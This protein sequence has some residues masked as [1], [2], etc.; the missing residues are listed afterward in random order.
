MLL[1]SYRD[2]EVGRKIVHFLCYYLLLSSTDVRRKRI[3]LFVDI[4]G[5]VAAVAHRNFFIEVEHSNLCQIAFVLSDIDFVL[6][7][8]PLLLNEYLF[9]RQKDLT[10]S[11][12]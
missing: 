2:K 10:V 11:R 8:M 12:H 9:S 5:C 3:A 4:S 1:M 7:N 6:I